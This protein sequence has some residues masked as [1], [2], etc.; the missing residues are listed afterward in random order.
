MV[1]LLEIVLLNCAYVPTD[2]L[3]SSALLWY[4]TFLQPAPLHS[5]MDAN[6]SL[7]TGIPKMLKYAVK[8]GVVVLGRR[9][10]LWRRYWSW[11]YERLTWHLH[12]HH[13]TTHF[14]QPLWERSISTRLTIIGILTFY[15]I[16]R[17]LG[18]LNLVAGPTSILLFLKKLP[19][20]CAASK[21]NSCDLWVHSG[22]PVHNLNQFWPHTR[23]TFSEAWATV[24]EVVN[25]GQLGGTL[26][27][28]FLFHILLHRE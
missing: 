3:R 9:F 19:N 15:R 17:L 6:A 28:S 20:F 26:L 21:L 12:I 25:I 7:A 2:C 27:G 22:R 11:H 8:C 13:I 14:R 1:V 23:S 16:W 10:K 18:D 24:N 5:F 4:L